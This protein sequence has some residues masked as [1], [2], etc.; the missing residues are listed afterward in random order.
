MFPPGFEP[1]EQRKKTDSDPDSSSAMMCMVEKPLPSANSKQWE[2]D[3]GGR[4]REREKELNGMKKKG[5][6]PLLI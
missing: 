4:K 1:G 3:E 2:S 6:L 5:T